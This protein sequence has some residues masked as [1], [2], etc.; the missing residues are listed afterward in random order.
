MSAIHILPLDA[1]HLSAV[2]RTD[3]QFLITQRLVP[4]ANESGL[5]YRILPCPPRVKSYD[6]EE[7]DIP[8]YLD[9]PE[10]AIFLAYAQ[11]QLA[12][13]IILRKYWNAYGYIDDIAVSP[14]FRR[15]GIGRLLLQQAQSWA[16]ERSLPGLMLETQDVNVPACQLYQACG[17]V[18]GGFDRF[19]YKALDPSSDE[20]A[21]YWYWTPP[22]P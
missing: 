8:S 22:K 21:L 1:A 10:R 2:F 13:Q 20:V 17:F 15:Q 6:P 7:I 11:D 4:I 19:L 9:H 12:G 14:A 16:M 5:S 18:F 3:S